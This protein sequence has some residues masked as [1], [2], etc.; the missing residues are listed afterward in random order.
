[1]NG[2][3]KKLAHLQNRIT[4]ANIFIPGFLIFFIAVQTNARS[5]AIICVHHFFPVVQHALVYFRLSFFQVESAGNPL[6]IVVRFRPD[7][8]GHSC[9]AGTLLIIPSSNIAN[10][11]KI[12]GITHYVFTCFQFFRY[13][14]HSLPSVHFLVA[15]LISAL[16]Y[17]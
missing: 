9:V 5:L 15:L 16:V 8:G 13:K 6:G 2:L 17:L 10:A 11:L 4:P 14:E 12:T 1:M 3:R 7:H